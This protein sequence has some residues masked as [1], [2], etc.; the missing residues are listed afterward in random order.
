MI[1]DP[2][3]HNVELLVPFSGI[4]NSTTILDKSRHNSALT[5]FA[6]AKITTSVADPFGS[7]LGVGY[8]DGTEDGVLVPNSADLML[9]NHDFTCEFFVYVIAGN[10]NVSRIY[11]PDGD[12]HH[13]L[14]ITLSADNKVMWLGA[15]E[16]TADWNAFFAYSDTLALNT[17]HY[18]GIT[19]EGDNLY[20]WFNGV[21]RQLTTLPLNQKLLHSNVTNMVIGG[22]HG[23]NRSLNGYLSN[24]RLTIGHARD[25]SV[26]P[27]EPLPITGYSV[28]L[29]L[30]ETIAAD[31]F[32]VSVHDLATMTLLNKTTTVAGLSVIDTHTAAPILLV[33]APQQ[34]DVWKPAKSYTVND[35]VFPTDPITS[36]FYYKRLNAGTSGTTEP[37]WS[38]A[39]NDNNSSSL[40][41][42]IPDG[43]G[44]VTRSA[45]LHTND[46]SS[47]DWVR[48]DR[49]SQP[50]TIGP[51]IPA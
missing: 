25:L 5:V 13:G 9:S 41:Y 48:V 30:T 34:G 20:E 22:Q 28:D 23:I 29:Q 3:F 12:Y 33:I 7:N 16:G 2:Y 24:F 35:L 43:D 45:K 8:F 37:T 17:W 26:R 15:K 27:T 14:S 42:T 44:T 21:K 38:V 40:V 31:S 49:L 46:G 1:K 32:N 19:R 51:L 6:D 18:L 39:G 36:P 4:H 50:V 10:P 11:N 47:N